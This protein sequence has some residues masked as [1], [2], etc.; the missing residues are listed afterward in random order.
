MDLKR[1][2]ISSVLGL[3]T[4][5]IAPKTLGLETKVKTEALQEKRDEKPKML[6]YYAAPEVDHNGAFHNRPER[7]KEDFN[8]VAREAYGF[9]GVVDFVEE[10]TSKGNIPNVLYI[11]FHG[12]PK[13]MATINYFEV[14]ENGTRITNYDKTLMKLGE[15]L[16]DSTT[17]VLGSCATGAE[18]E[19]YNVAEAINILTG[20]RVIA[21]TRGSSS[22]N[23]YIDD[24]GRVQVEETF[25]DTELSSTRL[26]QWELPWKVGLS[27]FFHGGSI[28]SGWSYYTIKPDTI[29]SGLSRTISYEKY[30]W[31]YAQDF[32]RTNFKESKENIFKEFK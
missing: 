21:P 25:Q 13:T 10:E 23:V 28:S 14:V 24:S 5:S 17:I 7:F 11:G 20:N 22:A 31:Q 29:Y 26:K 32:R 8:V 12:S 15:T 4:L 16:P 2:I 1:I 30:D 27:F 19:G 6:I 9:S 18:C 3:A